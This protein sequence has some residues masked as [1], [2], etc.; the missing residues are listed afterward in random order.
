MLDYYRDKNCMKNFC[1]DFK[2]H[3]TKTINY[4]KKMIP[5]TKEKQNIQC[6]QKKFYISKKKK[7]FST[8]DDKTNTLK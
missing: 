2:K 3:A 7:R 6:K 8:D 5:L 4:E 1:Q